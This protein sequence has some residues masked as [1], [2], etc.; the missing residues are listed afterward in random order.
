MFTDP[1]IKQLFNKTN[2]KMC[3]NSHEKNAWFTFKVI[4]SNFLENK[5]LDYYEEIVKNIIKKYNILGSN[6]NLKLHFLEA[7]LDFLPKNWDRVSEEQVQRF[8]KGISEIER[9]FH[10]HCDVHLMADYCWCLKRNDP[11]AS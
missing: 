10:G 9:C 1:Q 2:L 6:M 4:V 8:H 5:K 3:L 11:E 7:H